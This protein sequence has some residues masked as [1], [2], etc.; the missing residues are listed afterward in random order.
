MNEN[1]MGRRVMNHPEDRVLHLERA[2]TNLPTVVRNARWI[3][4]Y[5]VVVGKESVVKDDTRRKRKVALSTFACSPANRG[6]RKL[7]SELDLIRRKDL[8]HSTRDLFTG[9]TSETNLK[10]RRKRNWP[11]VKKGRIH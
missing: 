4:R 8:I 9:N 10:R 2:N 3:L 1:A 5:D 11:T 7:N 6:I